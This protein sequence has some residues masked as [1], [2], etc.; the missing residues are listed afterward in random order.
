[1]EQLVRALLVI[2]VQNDFCDGGVIEVPDG[3][4]V[5]ARITRFMREQVGVYELVLASQDCHIDPQGHFSSEPDFLSSW[6]KH[7]IKGSQGAKFHRA[8]DEALID[9]VITKGEYHGA[10]SAF[11]GATAAGESLLNLLERREIE[12]VDICGIATDFCVL[13]S[14]L[15]SLDHG[16]PTTVFLDLI[17][18]V[19]EEGSI[20]AFEE[21]QSRGVNLDYG[22]QTS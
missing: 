6:P 12:V 7:A 8:L 9:H 22:L 10:F 14:A 17:A 11:E 13:H 18:G 21:L 16:F 4:E 15:D 19:S 3:A 20:D 5:A 2:D 1:M